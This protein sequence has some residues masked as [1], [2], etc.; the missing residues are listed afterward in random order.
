MWIPGGQLALLDA[1][2]VLEAFR[3]QQAMGG[4]TGSWVILMVLMVGVFYLML[5]RP[6]AKQAK[7]H[8]AM[9]ASLKKGDVVV[10]SGG[11]IGKV[12]AVAEKFVTIEAGPNVRVRILLSAIAN[13]APEG[14]LD[15]K[16]ES[17]DEA[18]EKDKK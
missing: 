2:D 17:H 16:P 9:L 13:K 18:R 15:E 1:R 6:Q 8:K 14:L 5:W 4:G 7:E 11:I 10:T 3:A 12:A